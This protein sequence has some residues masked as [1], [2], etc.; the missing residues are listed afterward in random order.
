M[1]WILIEASQGELKVSG[2]QGSPSP[3]PPSLSLLAKGAPTPGQVLTDFVK[4]SD[5]L[6]SPK[7]F[8]QYFFSWSL[9]FFF[10]SKEMLSSV[11]LMQLGLDLG[12]RLDQGLF[13]FSPSGQKSPFHVQSDWEGA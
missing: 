6:G 4:Y 11:T 7:S 12:K 1:S 5:F 9:D 10:L 13:R 2:A 3:D 8:G